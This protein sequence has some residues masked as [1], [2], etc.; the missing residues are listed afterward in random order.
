MAAWTTGFNFGGN[1][2]DGWSIGLQAPMDLDTDSATFTLQD[3]GG[4]LFFGRGLV[5]QEPH[6]MHFGMARDA[7]GTFDLVAGTWSLDYTQSGGQSN[8]I[9]VHLQG[10]I[11]PR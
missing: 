7:A 2:Y 5:D 8:V 10:T 11:A 1:D 4:P 3:P 9:A 6:I